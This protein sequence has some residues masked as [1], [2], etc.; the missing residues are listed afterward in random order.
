MITKFNPRVRS[1]FPRLN[2]DLMVISYER[3]TWRIQDCL[4]TT[5]WSWFS[6]PSPKSSKEHEN[7]LHTVIP[8]LSQVKW[9]AGFPSACFNKAKRYSYV[10]LF[11]AKEN[12]WA[13]E[14]NNILKNFSDVWIPCL[15]PCF[16]IRSKWI[17]NFRHVSFIRTWSAHFAVWEGVLYVSRQINIR[18]MNYPTHK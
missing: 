11:Q 7:Y 16:S 18:K 6:W 13:E 4:S 1:T 10:M 15:F 12:L 8:V 3:S 9:Y 14:R 17:L 2:Y 5:L